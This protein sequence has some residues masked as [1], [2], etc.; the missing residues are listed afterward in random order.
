M[1]TSIILIPLLSAF[2]LL[3]VPIE[4]RSRIALVAVIGSV[5]AFLVSLVLLTGFDPHNSEM[6]F[7]ENIP[8][9]WMLNIHYL[10][11]V[12]G[13]SIWMIL[14]TTFL[15]V[16]A[17]L[18]GLKQEKNLRLFMMLL[19]ALEGGTI[20]VFWE[21]MLIPTYFLIG[22]WGEGDRIYATTKFVIYTLVGSLLM[23][24]AMI[25]LTFIHFDATH[26]LTFD[27][28]ELLLTHVDPDTQIWM[29]LFFFL[30]FAIKMPVFPF[31]SWLPH[32]Y[33]SCPIPVL[34]LLT[35]V[36][37]KT[38]AYGL[39]RFVVPLFP[40][41]LD[42]MGWFIGGLAATGM[43]YG[44]WVAIAQKDIK[45]LVAWSSISHLGFIVL[46]IF[47]LTDQGLEGS[48]LQMI[49]HGIIASALFV[50]VGVLE[51]KLGTRE[52]E[53][54]RGLRGVMPVM[55]GAFMLIT[56]AALGLPGLNGFVGEFLILIGVWKSNAFNGYSGI[57]VLMGGVAIVYASIYMLYFFQGTMQ[58]KNSNL[59]QGLRDVDGRDFG[60]LVPACLLIIIIGLYPKPFIEKI[61]SSTQHV[62][63]IEKTVGL[64]KD[65]SGGHH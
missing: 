21:L 22:L 32:T 49:N 59:P 65:S 43:V 3:W 57:Y 54:F 35:G 39:I 58:E 9:V 17:V 30:A 13:I 28:R 53:N 61:S 25:A 63:T 41:A 50:I 38:G 44:A 60:L 48:V 62:L 52:I 37:S 29:F 10:L 56:L 15:S 2:L 31:H 42:M 14:L 19:L 7:V 18:Y 34:I 20:G 1:L 64:P 46:G 26:H 11:G 6:Q 33:V 51:E 27:V 47:A 16:I 45:A 5:G 12:D 24:V 23:L 40:E 36:M 8:W 4:N 55:Y